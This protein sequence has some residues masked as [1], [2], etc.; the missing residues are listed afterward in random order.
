MRIECPQCDKL[1]EAACAKIADDEVRFSCSHCDGSFA[2]PVESGDKEA[3]VSTRAKVSNPSERCC[4][5]CAVPVESEQLACPS[6]G[7]GTE[8]FG[9]Y[10]ADEKPE[11]HDI[12]D[13]WQ[14]LAADWE[15]EDA[16][17]SF[18]HVVA[19]TSSYR[20]AAARYRVTEADASRAKR[21]RKMLD[22]I[23]TMATAALLATAPSSTKRK[24][25][26]NGPMVVVLL[27]LITVAA[28][29]VYYV[30]AK[31]N[32]AGDEIRYQ[33]PVRAPE[34][35][36]ERDKRQPALLAPERDSP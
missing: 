15:S 12:E 5:K 14:R 2:L 29:A 10:E 8:R 19:S 7:L 28:G 22:R 36:V 23:Q 3:R 1:F 16:H 34:N 11:D 20:G 32:A 4:P 27:L 26:V 6:C 25:A 35:A 18:M 21:S 17:E 13:A 30:F 33:A 24:D 31:G 9:D